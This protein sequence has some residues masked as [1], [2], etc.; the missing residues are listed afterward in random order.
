MVMIYRS[1]TRGHPR[2]RKREGPIRQNGRDEHEVRRFWND[3]SS[4]ILF[5]AFI[6]KVD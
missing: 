3:I 5:K 6:I 4:Y 2:P 1:K